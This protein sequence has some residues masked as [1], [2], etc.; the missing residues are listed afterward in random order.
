MN[1]GAGT[2]LVLLALLSLAGSL[3]GCK[4]S[5]VPEDVLEMFESAKSAEND[6]RP[7][8]AV[9]FYTEILNSHSDLAEIRLARGAS[10]MVQA[11]Q[12]SGED[13]EQ[14]L[15]AALVDFKAAA[16]LA[17]EPRF[18]VA[19]RMEQ[20]MCQIQLGLHSD[21]MTTLVWLVGDEAA[22]PREKASAHRHLGNLQLITLHRRIGIDGVIAAND[23]ANLESCREARLNFGDALSEMPKDGASLLGKGL[24]L[25][26]EQLFQEAEYYFD[27]AIDAGY[28]AGAI[29]V[30][31]TGVSR[32]L[33]LRTNE[34]SNAS[35]LKALDL[36]HEH[37]QFDPLYRKMYEVFEDHGDQFS[38]REIEHGLSML[39]RYRGKDRRVWERAK[40]YFE[41]RSEHPIDFLGL[42]VTRSRLGEA[43][44][45]AQSFRSWYRQ[46]NADVITAERVLQLVF[47]PSPCVEDPMRRASIALEKAHAYRFVFPN[48]TAAREPSRKDLDT[49]ITKLRRLPSAPKRDR[50]L[51]AGVALLADDLLE[52]IATVG[53]LTEAEREQHLKRAQELTLEERRLA[54]GFLA[55]YR[56]G[57]IQ[58]LLSGAEAYP[59]QAALETVKADPERSFGPAHVALVQALARLEEDR[60]ALDEGTDS[61]AI[62]AD[63]RN[64]E[65]V[66]LLYQG[67][68]PTILR[69]AR[70]IT[71]KRNAKIKQEQVLARERAEKER[72]AEE[73]R[74][75]AQQ[76]AKLRR[77]C[78]ECG[79]RALKTEAICPTC[80]W[81]LPD[82]DG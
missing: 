29:L 53:S 47:G 9:L 32:E 26:H 50:L 51:A 11:E 42:A 4:T 24:C 1:T 64:L 40:R 10:H 75:R 77:P 70:N 17:V 45:A 12:S 63:I 20:A 74:I 46:T 36:D 23:T 49:L 48:D 80:G 22:T 6:N 13:R 56:L 19:A 65:D 73:E 5:A 7:D 25:F 54:D 28:P 43:Q 27:Q 34:E 55:T 76:E 44:Q 68:D 41:P 38:R 3:A 58:Q 81:K 78:P 79:K 71:E 16:E 31:L 67:Q 60:Q 8:E 39:I 14:N 57:R 59:T 15:E 33:R 21:A 61:T 35:F 62:D 2:K 37:R 72:Q 52:M 69:A 30:Y 18:R 66:L 82:V